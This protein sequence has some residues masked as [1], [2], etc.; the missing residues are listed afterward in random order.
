MF[1]LLLAGP[2]LAMA[3]SLSIISVL[4]GSSATRA[5]IMTAVGSWLSGAGAIWLG[6]YC[7]RWAKKL[8]DGKPR[9]RPGE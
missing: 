5:E 6:I 9:A 8:V 2:I 7:F 4:D 3:M 1:L